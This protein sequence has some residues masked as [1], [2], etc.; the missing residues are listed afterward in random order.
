MSII[1]I[2]RGS[3]SGGCEL[4]DAV[5]KNLGCRVVSRE[6]LIEFA[7]EWGFEDKFWEDVSQKRLPLFWKRA[8]PIHKQ[9]IHLIKAKLL[10]Y[11][12]A[13]ALVYHGNAGQ[14]LLHHVPCVLRVKLIAPL[15]YRIKVAMEDHHFSR[16]ESETWLKNIDEIRGKWIKFLYGS[17]GN[18]PSMYDLII[19]IGKMSME[20]AAELICL[21]VLH[22]PFRI[23]DN[24]PDM[25]KD[26]S[27]QARIYAGLASDPRTRTLEITADVEKGIVKLS[28]N[29]ETDHVRKVVR[30]IVSDVE[31][32]E[33]VHG[34]L[35]VKR[36]SPMPTQGGL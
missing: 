23:E 7:K 9:Y 17:D 4:A 28:G 18:D 11:A 31:G 25:I 8:T 35:R 15:E 20:T 24:C 34:D 19:N 26:L 3:K 33:Q 10:E 21:S 1:T 16:S 2:S 13:G 29:V 32:V 36:L 30:A 22:R 12:E 5:A 27:L 6:M 14:F